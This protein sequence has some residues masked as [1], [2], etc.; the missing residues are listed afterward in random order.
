MSHLVPLELRE[1][2]AQ[3]RH[4]SLRLSLRHSWVPE[5]FRISISVS[6]M[7]SCGCLGQASG[8]SD[9][10]YGKIDQSFLEFIGSRLT[11]LRRA[12]SFHFGFPSIAIVSQNDK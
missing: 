12:I 6:N 5:T 1:V 8:K 4:G 3:S 10:A 11:T 2:C 7:L 9:N